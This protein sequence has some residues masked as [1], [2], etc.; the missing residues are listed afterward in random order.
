MLKAPYSMTGAKISRPSKAVRP[1]D[2]PGMGMDGG[3]EAVTEAPAPGL[4]SPTAMAGD[5]AP[6]SRRAGRLYAPDDTACA[7]QGVVSPEL[8]R[9]W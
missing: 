9:A 1:E 8:I 3:V 7:Q 6:A 2:W 5:S 4:N